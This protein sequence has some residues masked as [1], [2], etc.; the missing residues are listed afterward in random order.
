MVRVRFAPSPTGLLHIGGL[1]TAL[2]NYLFAKKHGGTFILRIEDTD[3]QRYVEEAEQD[4]LDSLAWAGLPVDEGPKAG[5]D[6]G[7]YYQSQRKD[8][9]KEYVDLLIAEGHA[10]YAFDSKE[11]L[12][13]MRARLT[14][15]E[16]PSPKYDMFSRTT[17]KNSFTMDADEVQAC[18]DRGEPFVV[19]L[20]VPADEQVQGGDLVRGTVSFASAEIDDQILLKSDGMPTYHLANVV[21]D[22][23][24]GITHIIRGEEWLPS[25][26]KHMLL[27]SAFG[28]EAPQTAHL[29]LILSPSGGKL[30]KRKA[31]K[32]G[33]PVFVRDYEA[34]GYEPEAFVNCTSMRINIDQMSKEGAEEHQRK[35]WVNNGSIHLLKSF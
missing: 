27:Y 11:D 25:T 21:D 34:A 15:P 17:M 23:L 5:G 28:W 26:P 22:H 4:I 13:E 8:I 1:R 19:R 32:A 18:I 12:D 14:T 7:P 31:E 20:K 30:S 2:Y 33:I 29:P 9:Y 24:M 3:R 16:N 10:Y 35:S 6:Y